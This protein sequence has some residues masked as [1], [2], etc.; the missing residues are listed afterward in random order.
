MKRAPDRDQSSKE[1]MTLRDVATYLHVHYFTV[2][3]MVQEGTIRSFRLGGPRG[4]WRVLRSEITKWIAAQ[5]GRPPQSATK[6]LN[7]KGR[8]KSGA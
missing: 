6:K 5:E 2:Y 1:V 7:G 3:R 4:S 8:R